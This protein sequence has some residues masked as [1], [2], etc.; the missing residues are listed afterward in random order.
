MIEETIYRC[1]HCGLG[2]ANAVEI[3]ECERGH[4]NHFDIIRVSFSAKS[5]LPDDIIISGDLPDGKKITQ[6]Y[7]K[8]S[9]S[10]QFLKRR[11]DAL[12]GKQ[13]EDK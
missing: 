12:D 7:R 11:L 1:E 13:E 2:S 8:Y 6:L 10:E 5:E 3:T 9:E 4:I